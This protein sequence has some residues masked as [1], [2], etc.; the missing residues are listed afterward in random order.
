MQQVRA[1]RDERMKEFDSNLRSL[2]ELKPKLE[3]TFHELV[4]TKST[5]VG[6][7][8]AEEVLRVGSPVCDQSLKPPSNSLP[9]VRV[10]RPI[11]THYHSA[12]KHTSC[13]APQRAAP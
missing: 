5:K 11:A 6:I 10:S 12:E 8:C 2:A 7:A 3:V 13:S 9:A 1:Q 4:V